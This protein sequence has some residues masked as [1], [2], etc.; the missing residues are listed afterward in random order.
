MRPSEFHCTCTGLWS[1][2]CGYE[3]ENTN[4][5]TANEFEI[6]AGRKFL[7]Q[8]VYFDLQQYH[9][10][11]PRM[12]SEDGVLMAVGTVSSIPCS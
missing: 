3:V 9:E 12:I 4:S 6:I 11:S 2:A 7:F 5:L 8:R 10:G 1:Y